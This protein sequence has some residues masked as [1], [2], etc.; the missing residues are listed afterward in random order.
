MGECIFC[1]IV[2]KRLPSSIVY[3]DENV[4]A[5]L[6]I[7][8]VSEGHT[9][10]VPKRHFVTL[11][12]CEEEVAKHLVVVLKRLNISVSKAVHC[13]GVLNAVMNGEFAGQ[14]VFHLHF[15][16]IPRFKNDGF[17]FRFPESY[18]IKKEREIFDE[19]ASRIRKCV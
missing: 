17:G 12:D 11:N 16:I 7:K 14:E 5:F 10:V 6:D 19:V 15:H 2:N 9:L 3:E 18:E 8:P 13:D 1:K 4:V